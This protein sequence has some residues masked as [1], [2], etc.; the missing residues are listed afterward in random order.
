MRTAIVVGVVALAS[1]VGASAQK[2]D[3]P[4]GE[5]VV[6]DVS[7]KEVKLTGAKL[8]TG[9]RRLGW[10]ARAEGT[11]EDEKKG[12]LVIE[13]REPNSTT[14]LKGIVTLIPAA[15]LESAKYDYEKQ[16]VAFTL[17]G[18]KEPVT[19]TLEFR[20][21]NMLG[22]GG[23]ADGKATSLTGGTLGKTSL[24]TVMFP[25]AKEMPAPRTTGTFWAV[26]IN[27]PAAK[28][29][30]LNVRNLKALYQFPGGV[31]QLEDGIPVRKG[32]PI[33]FNGNLKRF[34]ML[35]NDQNTNMAAA[36]VDVTGSGE[37]V[38]A[39]PL[40]TELDKKTG[41]L[42]GFLGEVDAGWKLF[43]LHTIKVI[44]LTAVKKKID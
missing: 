33:P 11:T 21:I 1:V 13:V 24:K 34:E 42:V 14:L 39:I 29:P 26:Q 32:P 8:T 3:P 20:G 40:T 7:G 19:G 12:P 28:D 23:T 43:P 2:D 44:T 16:V 22:I 27:H 15:S 30:T 18:L 4:G 6:T 41:T 10:L 5:V 9:T 25:G 17:K 35:A 38:I 36:E 31:E 37:R